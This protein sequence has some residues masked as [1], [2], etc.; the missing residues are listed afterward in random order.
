MQLTGYLFNEWD[1]NETDKG[2]ANVSFLDHKRNFLYKENGDH[3]YAGQRNENSKNGF[4]HSK[5]GLCKISVAISIL[6]LIRFENLS[7]ESIVC[8]SLEPDVN[9]ITEEQDNSNST[10][11]LERFSRDHGKFFSRKVSTGHEGVVVNGWKNQTH[12]TFVSNQLHA[13]VSR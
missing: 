9:E 10:R 13:G 3:R 5:L 7:E 4:G 11:D 2:V 1:E 8:L 12:W 6:V